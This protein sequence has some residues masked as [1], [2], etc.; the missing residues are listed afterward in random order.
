M[1]SVSAVH[2]FLLHS[3]VVAGFATL[4][5]FWLAIGAKKG[6]R[7]HTRSGR[8]FVWLGSYVALSAVA[9]SAWALASPVGFLTSRGVS[10]AAAPQRAAQLEFFFATLLF[11][12]V[13]LLADLWLGVRLVETKH[14]PRDLPSPLVYGMQW[15][16]VA[17]DRR[18]LARWKCRGWSRLM[19]ARPSSAGCRQRARFG[20]QPAAG[21][22]LTIAGRR[23]QGTCGSSRASQARLTATC[24]SRSR[25][26]RLAPCA[27]L[28]C[29]Q[30]SR[31]GPRR[32]A[33]V[34]A[35]D[36]TRL[37]SRSGGRSCR[38]LPG[39]RARRKPG[40]GNPG[41]DR[42]PL[43]RRL[44]RL[45]SSRP[46]PISRTRESATSTITSALRPPRRAGTS[47]RVP[48]RSSTTAVR[49]AWSAGTRPKTRP[50]RSATPRVKRSTEVSIRTELRPISVR[51]DKRRNSG[52][53]L[54]GDNAESKT[55]SAIGGWPR[56]GRSWGR[57]TR[58]VVETVLAFYAARAGDR[59]CGPLGTGQTGTRKAA[60]SPWCRGRRPTCASTRTSTSSSWTGPGTRTAESSPGRP[61]PIYGR[62]RWGRPW[63]G[64]CGVWR[65]TSAGAACSAWTR[66][67]TIL[68]ATS[69]P[70]RS[71][72]WPLPRGRSG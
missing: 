41:R 13:G 43:A 10:A 36:P 64:W 28:S 11:L 62:A 18:R 58:L 69:P 47:G 56:T 45:L 66:T 35:L 15:L 29:G 70:R 53:L 44:D 21:A 1:P 37:E 22:R 9:G 27:R 4:A 6:S 72:A 49:D 48:R 67:T 46:A 14:R 55:Y 8:V 20:P 25:P 16:S 2:A 51:P 54:A 59:R 17:Q 65:G 33:A 24:T 42:R 50:V 40:C 26:G 7:L 31:A 3:H 52:A 38:G 57:L 32:A 63:S 23:P 30:R 68:K 34:S 61:F 12:G 39:S 71:R 19:Q 60:P 5:A